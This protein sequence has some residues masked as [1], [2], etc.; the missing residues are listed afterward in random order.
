MRV[1]ACEV[2]RVTRARKHTGEA[3]RVAGARRCTGLHATLA[4][5]QHIKRKAHSETTRPVELQISSLAGLPRGGHLCRILTWQ[6]TLASPT[7]AAA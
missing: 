3:A 6:V 1:N 2:C 5:M 7:G 4:C